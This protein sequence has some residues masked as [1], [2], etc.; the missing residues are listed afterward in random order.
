MGEVFERKKIHYEEPML[1]QRMEDLMQAN[2]TAR[3]PSGT[4]L[5]LLREPHDGS[6]SKGEIH[7]LN[8]AHRDRG[9]IPLGWVAWARVDDAERPETL[10]DPGLYHC[11][12][13][14][15]PPKGVLGSVTRVNDK[16][17]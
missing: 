6:G 7:G 3:W 8:K 13:V 17:I 10:T 4:S 9:L 2:Q 11:R 14:Y 1:K 15:V 16:K 5:V 12:C